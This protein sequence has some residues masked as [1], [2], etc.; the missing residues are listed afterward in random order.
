MNS[1]VPWL[2]LFSV[3]FFSCLPST[4]SDQSSSDIALAYKDLLLFSTLDGKLYAV[5]KVTGDTLWKL[6]S[7]SPIV[8]HL[9]SSSYLYLTDPKDGSLYMSGPQSDGIKRLPLTIPE[10]VKISPCSSS[11]G[12]LYSGSKQ[13]SWIAV[14][15]LTGRKLYS[16]SSHDGMNSMCPPNQ[17]GSNKIIHIPSI[18]YRVAVLDSKTKQIKVN[19]TYTQYGTQSYTA[20]Q[21]QDLLHLSSSSHGLLTSL[22][23]LTGD[24]VWEK[25]FGSPVV[26]IYSLEKSQVLRSIPFTSIND[27]TLQGMTASRALAIKNGLYSLTPTDTILQSSFFVGDHNGQM[28]VMNALTEE[29]SMQE[30]P[31]NV[32]LIDGPQPQAT[33]LDHPSFS[34]HYPLPED[35]R[36]KIE[37][38]LSEKWSQEKYRIGP[39]V[40]NKEPLQVVDGGHIDGPGP[41]VLGF[42]FSLLLVVAGTVVFSSLVASVVAV[43]VTKSTQNVPHNP[44]PIPTPDSSKTGSHTSKTHSQT[45]DNSKGGGAIEATDGERG[46]NRSSIAL[47][48]STQSI[49]RNG[50]RKYP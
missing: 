42:S 2:L 32:P 43:L 23:S 11:D 16:F 3:G 20:R 25:D 47:S 18:E 27:D 29:G 14:D 17:Y 22:N 12:L 45:T 8:T 26:G 21:S 19:I 4:D 9:S 5:D 28:Y 31:L 34:G 1:S 6:N 7:K 50:K 39:T 24:K 40:Q 49:Y 33:S 38:L 10:L 30:L 46:S 37:Q 41:D 36:I 35:S 48:D 44:S 13:D 15:A